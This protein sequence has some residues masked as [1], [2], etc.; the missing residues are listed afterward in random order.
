MNKKQITL[1][2][3]L[4]VAVITAYKLNGVKQNENIKEKEV[5]SVQETTP[6][7]KQN[8][9]TTK[10]W[11]WIKT[12]YNNDTVVQPL[13]KEKFTLTLK[14][15]KTFSATTD[16]NNTGGEYEITGNKISFTKMF[17]TLMYCEG[18]QEAEFIKMLTE[19]QGYLLT[20]SGD[21]VLSLKMDSG[22]MFFK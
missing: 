1:L 12:I 20:S 3:I 16:C 11:T 19:T 4:I 2:I 8:N 14:K 5:I 6:V 10:S 7:I 18:S 13:N 17:S 21:L 15:D 22:S 9:I